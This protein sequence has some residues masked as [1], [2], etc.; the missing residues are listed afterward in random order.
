MSEKKSSKKD[1]IVVE[2]TDSQRNTAALCYLFF[3]IGYFT[4]EKDSSYVKFHMEQS[5]ALLVVAV[6]L[7]LINI[8]PILGQLIY[9]AGAIAVIVIFFIGI[10]NA[11]G[12]RQ[13]KLPIIGDF[14]D[15]FKL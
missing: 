12:G 10:G 5:L 13:L 4:K 6:V 3:A 8:I 1:T 15:N 7:S 2:P 14:A 9:L 11:L